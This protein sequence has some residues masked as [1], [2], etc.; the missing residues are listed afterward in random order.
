MTPETRILVQYRISWAREALAEASLLLDSGYAN[1]SVNRLYYACFY[2]V[3]ALLLTKGLTATS[4]SG[5]RTLFHQHL[6]RPGLLPLGQGPLYDRLFDQRQ[7]SDYADLVH[8]GVDEVHAWS[9][10]AQ[11]FVDAVAVLIQQALAA[12]LP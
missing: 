4:H 6:I 7:R 8:F 11:A 2:A 5:L 1:T 10:D 3:S 12:P 9:V